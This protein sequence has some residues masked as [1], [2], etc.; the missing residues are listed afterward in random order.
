MEQYEAIRAY[1]A[2]NNASGQSPEGESDQPPQAG[3]NSATAAPLSDSQALLD[4]VEGGPPRS[5]R[6]S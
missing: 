1:L 2:G 5:R 6:S 3:D 4:G